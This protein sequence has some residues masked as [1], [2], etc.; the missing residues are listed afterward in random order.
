MAM[1]RWDPLSDL[2]SIHER[3]D[4]WTA[5]RTPGWTPPVDVY[6][7]DDRYVVSVEIPGLAREDIDIRIHDGQL[8]LQGSRPSLRVPCEQY[9]RIERGHG[10]FLRTLALP[11]AV[12]AE[13][14]LAD[15]RDGVLTISIPKLANRGS[16]RIVVE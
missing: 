5:G 11:H 14:T 4:R 8:T 7:T 9:H 10:G 3:L 2:L 1:F 15:L 13:E 16:R 12:D 6:E